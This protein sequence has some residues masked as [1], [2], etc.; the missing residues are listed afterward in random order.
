MWH[1]IVWQLRGIQNVT[2]LQIYQ[3][4]LDLHFRRYETCTQYTI[5]NER[6]ECVMQLNLA[7]H[8]RVCCQNKP[9]LALLLQLRPLPPR[10]P[11]CR[12][13]KLYDFSRQKAWVRL[14]VKMLFEA[15]SWRTFWRT[16]LDVNKSRFGTE[17]TQHTYNWV[18]WGDPCYVTGSIPD[19]QYNA[20]LVYIR[21]ARN[22]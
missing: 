1:R 21:V 13:S 8:L 22:K 18:A 17:R 14:A 12:I 16:K 20:Y 10:P 7:I 3:H 15:S 11:W 6:S 5:V 4:F 2:Q 19:F 9:L